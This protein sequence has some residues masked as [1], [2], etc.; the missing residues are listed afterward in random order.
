MA[1]DARKP[2]HYTGISD[3]LYTDTETDKVQEA[4]E[5]EACGLVALCR[6]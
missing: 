3:D 4:L 6:P 1:A 5:L 2:V